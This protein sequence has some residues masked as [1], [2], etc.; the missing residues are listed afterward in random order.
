MLLKDFEETENKLRQKE[1][2]TPIGGTIISI[3][4][5]LLAEA[6][7]LLFPEGK[8]KKLKWYQPKRIWQLAQVAIK[9]INSIMAVTRK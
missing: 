5:L 2:I 8:Y 4:L 3:V 1:I 6:K 9:L 7:E